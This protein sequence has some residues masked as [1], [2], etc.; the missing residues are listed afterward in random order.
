MTPKTPSLS[1]YPA[2]ATIESGTSVFLTCATNSVVTTTYIFYNGS[3]SVQSAAESTYNLTS[4]AT[5]DSGYYKCVAVING[6][7][8]LTSNALTVTIVGR[9]NTHYD[10]IVHVS[11]NNLSCMLFEHPFIERSKRKD[12]CN[13][14]IFRV[15]RLKIWS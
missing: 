2:N 8:S 15:N 7:S 6:V 13:S 1:M 10:F 11:L 4:A 5:T 3:I 12:K 9:C 14:R